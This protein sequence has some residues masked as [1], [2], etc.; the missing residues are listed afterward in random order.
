MPELMPPLSRARMLGSAFAAKFS[1]AAFTCL[2]WPLAR[3]L[4]GR[5]WLYCIYAMIAMV[6]ALYLSW[7]LPET[8]GRRLVDIWLDL[9]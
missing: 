6:A 9:G 1:I 3:R 2:F 5:R 8:K 4:I 7:R